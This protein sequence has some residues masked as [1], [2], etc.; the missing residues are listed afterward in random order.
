MNS[1]KVMLNR[2]AKGNKIL[3][4]IRFIVYVTSLQTD[5]KDKNS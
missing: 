5:K 3:G 1:P 4:Q 2:P